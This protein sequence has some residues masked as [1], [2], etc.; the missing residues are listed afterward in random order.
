[1]RL[2]HVG[3]NVNGLPE[4]RDCL[5]CLS[6]RVEAE[7]QE[8]VETC[9]VR[10]NLQPGLDCPIGAFPLLMSIEPDAQCDI[11]VGVGMCAQLRLERWRAGAGQTVCALSG[12]ETP[13]SKTR[14]NDKS[15]SGEIA[16]RDHASGR[17]P[18]TSM[19][20]DSPPLFR[21]STFL[22]P[23]AST[24]SCPAKNAA[25]HGFRWQHGSE[26]LTSRLIE[27]HPGS[28]A[29]SQARDNPVRCLRRAEGRHVFTVP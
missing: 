15:D 17:T 20:H 29:G 3:I 21:F 8:I 10:R 9:G 22:R 18:Q 1:M 24:A 16:M 13:D 5:L 2:Q 7:P 6:R 4:W 19:M 12:S 23:C 26:K 28:Q 25:A 27:R 14:R 11:S